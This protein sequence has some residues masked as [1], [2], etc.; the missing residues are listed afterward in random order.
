MGEKASTGENTFLHGVSEGAAA[1]TSH[2]ALRDLDGARSRACDLRR[3][4]ARLYSRTHANVLCG[5][6]SASIL[7]IAE[8]ASTLNSS[9][10]G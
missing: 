3:L 4:S 6:L 5:S 2:S 9:G 7:D 1:C 10:V 8:A